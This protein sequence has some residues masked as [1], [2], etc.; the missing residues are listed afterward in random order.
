KIKTQISYNRY[1]DGNETFIEALTTKQSNELHLLQLYIAILQKYNIEKQLVVTSKRFVT[2]FD[3]DFESIEQLADVLIY[4]PKSRH[5]LEPASIEYRYP[6]FN[7]NYANNYG[8]FIREKEFGGAKMGIGEVGWIDIASSVQTHDYTDIDI[9]LS[10]EPSDPTIHTVHK[11][12]GY[13]ASNYQIIKDY[14]P[15]ERYEEI[16]NEIAENFTQKA[17]VKVKKILNDGS[18]NIG[19]KP[20]TIDVTFSGKDL[21]QKA[22]DNYLCNVGVLIGKQMELYQVE[23]RILP[24]E[25]YYPHYYTRNI[26]IK[27]PKDFVIKNP[28]V[29]DMKYSTVIDGKTKA[30]WESSAKVIADEIVV[31]NTE[32]YEAIEY[33]LSVF[34]DY[35]KVV[36]A[37]ADFNKIVVVV[38]PKE[39]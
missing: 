9:D 11:Q 19:L 32:Y 3:K 38:G 20:F 18:E 15:N 30:Y 31:T 29:F 16:T 12:S 21:V 7:F 6:M 26:K 36:N 13:S 14:V 33:P 4:F 35:K 22:G 1:F 34:E 39:Q 37:A 23:K 8:L 10:Q 25:I 2:Y 5:Y 17:P 27:M 28:E 24:V